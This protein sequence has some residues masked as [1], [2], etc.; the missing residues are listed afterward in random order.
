MVFAK[1]RKKKERKWTK[2]QST[3]THF[4]EI[5][6]PCV[7]SNSSPF[8]FCV[9][10]QTRMFL[11]II[12]VNMKVIPERSKG[13]SLLHLTLL[14]ISEWVAE[15]WDRIITINFLVTR[16]LFAFYTAQNKCCY[17]KMSLLGTK[18]DPLKHSNSKRWLT[19]YFSQ[20]YPYI[21]QQVL[22]F[23]R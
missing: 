2:F 11:I 16:T 10:Q 13:I 22:E 8:L 17:I 7:P 23:I 21:I 14:T 6:V 19:S 12:K 3:M 5:H 15:A 9:P 4:G 1:N 20:R 18:I